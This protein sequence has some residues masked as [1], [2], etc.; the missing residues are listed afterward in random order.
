MTLINGTCVAISG[1]GVLIRGPSGM[2]KS[3]LALRLIDAGANLVSDDYCQAELKDGA[4]ILTAPPAIKGKL[5][6]RGY[7]IV[8]LSALAFVSVTLVV[9]LAPESRINRM[10]ESN[11]C[12]VEGARLKHLVL[13]AYTPSAAAKIRLA[14]P[15]TSEGF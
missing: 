9:D 4:L 7:G 14:L 12:V 3:D 6:V 8:N 13:D 15:I 10:P 2:A 11:T 5:E 1:Q